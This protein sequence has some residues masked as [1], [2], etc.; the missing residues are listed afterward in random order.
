M[1][2]LALGL[3]LTAP[4]GMDVNY[5]YGGEGDLDG[6]ASNIVIASF[7]GQSFKLF[8]DRSSSLPVG[9]SFKAPKMPRVIHFN[10]EVQPPAD[11]TKDTMVFRKVD[12]SK[13]MA[14]FTV[15]FS[16]YRAVNGVQ[17]PFKWTQTMGGETD[18]IFE[19]TGYELNPANIGDKFQNQQ[20][21]WKAKKPDGQ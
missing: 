3:L 6:T 15:R 21:H 2:R 13:A 11:G 8:L 9:M 10:K 12:A 17:L 19:V 4:Q 14:E 7:G 1:L 16:D 5:T 18:E 20:I